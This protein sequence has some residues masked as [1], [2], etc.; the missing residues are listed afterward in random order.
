MSSMSALCDASADP[1]YAA[2]GTDVS[3]RLS[4]T[5]P[6]E[7]AEARVVS[8]VEGGR[9][10]GRRQ[11]CWHACGPVFAGMCRALHDDMYSDEIGVGQNTCAQRHR[12]L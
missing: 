9:E 3:D 1:A 6:F 8:E 4:L 7:F 5:C 2:A 12:G 11:E 10:G